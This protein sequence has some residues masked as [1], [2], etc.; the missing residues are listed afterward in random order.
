MCFNSI[1]FLALNLTPQMIRQCPPPRSPPN[2]PPPYCP[3]Y[4][5]R[6]ILVGCCVVPSIGG[7]LRPKPCLPLNILIGLALAP[8]TGEPTAALPNPMARNLHGPIG[9]S[10]AMSWGHRCSTHGG[11][12]RGRLRVERRRC[13]CCCVCCDHTKKNYSTSIM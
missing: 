1:I 9:S 12:G 4:R 3:T 2:A 7:H 6:R 13:F 5:V 10:G 11:R 8:Q